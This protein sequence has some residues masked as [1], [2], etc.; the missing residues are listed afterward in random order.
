[1]KWEAFKKRVETIKGRAEEDEKA[2]NGIKKSIEQQ[3]GIKKVIQ[4]IPQAA[5]IQVDK[6]KERLKEARRIAISEKGVYTSVSFN[7]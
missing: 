4:A 5:K 2:F 7:T 1:M 6:E 3:E